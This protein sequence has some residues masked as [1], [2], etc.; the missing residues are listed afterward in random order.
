MNSLTPHIAIVDDDASVRRAFA[1]LLRA[2][3]L[4]TRA[5]ASARDFFQSL[6]KE[7]PDCLIVD[8]QM[9]EMTGLEL[10]SE[11][12]QL[13]MEIPTI[14]ATAHDDAGC[15]ERCH[16]AGATFLLKPFNLAALMVAMNMASRRR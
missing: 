3:A 5:Y 1:R 11:L 12:L 6:K 15:R 16:A 14:I 7:V 2:S 9:P 8:L 13:G 10:H 4:D